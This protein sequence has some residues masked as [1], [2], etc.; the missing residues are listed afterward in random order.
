[1]TDITGFGLGGH[2]LNIVSKSNV[3]AKL[4]LDQI[5]VYPG[6]NNLIAKDIRSSIFEN[7]YMYSERM[8]IKTTANTD[9]LFDPQTSGPLLATV[10]KS[11][12]KGIIISGEKLGFECKVIG[13][14]TNG[15][16]YIEVL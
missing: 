7:N 2:L 6:A 5:P 10:P 4:Y 15:K 9:I 13:E 8:I 16:P 14:L 11:K 12:V 3:G 1:M